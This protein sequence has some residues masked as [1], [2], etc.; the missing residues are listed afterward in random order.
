[1]SP[2]LGID[3][4]TT[5]AVAALVT[6]REVKIVPHA[7][8]LFTLPAVVAFSPVAAGGRPVVGKE[9]QAV[10]VRHPERTIT[11]V[12]RLLGRKLEAPEARHQRQEVPYELVMAKNGD[13]RIRVGR[14]HH[15]PPD[16]AA[17]IFGSLKASAEVMAG[18]PVTDAVVAVPADFN[19]LQRQAIVDAAR[20]AGLNVVAVMTE[21]AAVAL[22]S[23]IYPL[24]RGHEKK[25][26]KVLVYDLG[27]GSFNV[28]ALVVT[29]DGVEVLASGG[30]A[31]LG[32]EDFDQRIVS[33][34]CEHFMKAGGADL[35]RERLLMPRLRD[36]AEKAKRELS[37]V[38][39]VSIE[40]PELTARLPAG[41]EL[42]RARLESL[43]QDLVDRTVWPCETV[44]HDAK[45]SVEDVEALI[46]VGGQTRMPR[47]RAHI[48]DWLG[49]APID[50]PAPEALIAIGAARQ[51]V[52]L[53][54]GRKRKKGQIAI[55][56]TTCLSL[57]VENAGGVVTR[58]VPKGTPLPAAQTQIL[59]TSTDAQAHVT[60]HL[61]QGEREMAADNDSIARLQ[62]GPLQPA[63]R[64]VP[65]IEIL[66]ATDGSGIPRASARDVVTDEPLPVRVRPSGGLSEVE[67]AAL[68]ILHAGSSTAAAPVEDGVA[69]DGVSVGAGEAV[70]VGDE[71]RRVDPDV[72]RG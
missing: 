57:G 64:G 5:N 62:I 22:A 45:W 44:L 12:K 6:G 69:S 14:R 67:I 68:I 34:V 13:A 41:V 47:V 55:T 15:A 61:L 53:A 21:P 63:P 18:A 48:T 29:D 71:A 54:A 16:V 1:M 10:A 43:T 38:D 72:Q 39:S 26:R 9:A 49:R 65:Q 2:L 24:P 32:G 37:F 51:G 8:G 59:S 35:R 7:E 30:D 36:A 52:A 11:S 33:D 40:L 46:M 28:A 50:V 23:G 56:E 20:I 31:F 17:Y 58:L 25:E 19:D 60:V 66:I 4:G 27:G 42:D 3:F 70:S